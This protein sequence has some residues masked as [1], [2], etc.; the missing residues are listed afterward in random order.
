[1]Q[2]VRSRQLPNVHG[3]LRASILRPN[4]RL[5][6]GPHLVRDELLPGFHHERRLRGRSARIVSGSA[7]IRSKPRAL[8]FCSRVRG[9]SPSLASF[10]VFCVLFG[11][12]SGVLISA[13]P[14]VIAHPVVSPTPAMVG[15]RMG[16]QWFA[17]SLGIL[18]GA[19]IA[20]VIEGHGGG[21]GYLGL[22]VFCGAVMAVGALFLLVPLM[23]VWKHD[24]R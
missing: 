18:I 13:N 3:L 21:N 22:Q 2:R 6:G 7:E 9:S 16:M 20:G 17:T 23:A 5:P 10:I 15:T 4:L 11:V 1:M 14:I 24:S 8:R 19:P 12:F